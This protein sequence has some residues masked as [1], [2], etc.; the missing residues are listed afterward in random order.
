VSTTPP[1]VEMDSEELSP[2]V[3]KGKGL[4][5]I[6]AGAPALPLLVLFGLNFVD[7]F[8][9]VAFAAVISE[10][11]DAFDLSD[12]GI[13]RVAG[14]AGLA[15]LLLS[16]PMGFFA[17][18][19]N[20]V[21]MSVIAAGL[22]GVC[23]AFTGIVP[24]VW[25]LF[26]VRLGAGVGR[27]IN[28]VVHPS[29]L[30]DLYPRKS[31]PRVFGLH[32]MANSL[33]NVAGPIA[34]IIA[35]SIAWQ[36]SFFILAVPTALL[37]VAAFK[38]REPARGESVDKEMALAAAEEEKAVPFGEAYRQLSSARTLKRFWLGAFLLGVGAFQIG[39]ILSLFFE[40]VYDYGAV[41][42][43]FVQFVLGAG[44]VA[45]LVVGARMATKATGEGNLPRLA[46]IT[47]LSF[48][49]FAAGCILLAIS[50]WAPL[51]L[52]ACFV[53]ALGIGSYQP[54]YFSLL[55]I[56][57]PPRVRSQS[58]AYGLLWYGMGGLFYTLFLAGIGEDVSYRVLLVV[59]AVV[60][61]LSG[62]IGASARKY[63]KR[64][65]DQAES[66]L[67]TAVNIRKALAEAGA[68]RSLLVCRGVEVAYDQVQVLFG[69]DMEVKEG[70][71]VALLGTNGAGKSTLL[72]AISGTEDPIG[73][74]IFFDG[75]DITHADAVQT[76]KAGI[77]QVPGGKA[78]F[79]TL[80]VAEHLR[81]AGWLFRDDP[82]YLKQANE[83]VLEIF[84]RL[85][86]RYEQMA[87]NLSGGEQQMLALGMA[88]IAKPKLL[89]IDEL[90]LGLA[91]T[92]VEQLLG[93]VRRIQQSGTAIILV[94]Q[95]I[96]VALTVAERAYFMEK[97]EVRFSGSTAEL[98]ERDDIVRSVFLEGAASTSG[99]AGEKPT[100]ARSRARET[101]DLADAKPILQMTGVTKRFGGITA[102]DDTTLMLK[103]GEIL[104]LIGPN[105]AG[106]T[107]IF[108]LVSG[109]LIP[110]EG[111]IVL[112]GTDVT[113]IS[114]DARAWLG[115]GRSFQ[116]A[117]L[118]PSLTVAENIAI[119]LE[120]HLETRDHVAAALNLPGV[121]RLEEDV[122]W[123]VE[124]L[125]ELMNLGSFR[126]KFV[127][128]LSTGSRRIV[129]LAMTIGHDPKVLLLDEPSSGIAQR[130]T[131]ALGPLLE[132]I[133]RETGCALLVIEHDM[134]LITGISD[135]MYALEL[136]H[137]I[138]EGTPQEVT[139]DPRVVSSY[140]GG[141]MAVI[142][143]SGKNPSG[144]GS[145]NGSTGTT[146]RRRRTRA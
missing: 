57:A 39:N 73:G 78:V 77:V 95:S 133:R 101:T 131:E 138:A 134:P 91:P 27:I 112:D 117:R 137:P 40:E 1:A 111:K 82:D 34:G 20:R 85:R 102:V 141:D 42:R 31:H 106:K 68:D 46:T 142:N 84:P 33:G 144:N 125:I 8:D 130:E 143:R 23:A 129:D 96:N 80:T 145:G 65:V 41:G 94:E 17:D 62:L 18:R 32:R 113:N 26:I 52:V 118:V 48:V 49:Q 28:E 98:M 19:F 43:G 50:P 89:M 121:I 140:L 47:G 79:P 9:R 64:D 56:V 54:A 127:R 75:R 90:S 146:T 30:S 87:G 2:D 71:I 124:D 136:G 139:S 74:A 55:G 72:K 105:G 126:D 93:I 5:A 12:E 61:A 110:D 83:E 119:G 122:A 59:L 97:G 15:T 13:Q 92:I 109:F 88:F 76:A 29:L 35:A 86:E 38:L 58:Y 116:D 53:L 24:T 45:G 69:A 51:G 120:R 36:A 63:V 132:R 6:T 123:T 104:G 44:T 128:E 67:S 14:L 81:A 7:E 4:S 37:L 21:R 107:T 66:T 135:R 10:I 25:L 3:P 99:G 115:L 16:L 114:P 22:W 70:E 103:D 60:T 11:R 100:R 108:D